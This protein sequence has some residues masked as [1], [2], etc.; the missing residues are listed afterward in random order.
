MYNL[1]THGNPE[2]LRIVGLVIYRFIVFF[3]IAMAALSAGQYLFDIAAVARCLSMW[4][5]AGMTVAMLGV[6]REKKMVASLKICS[7]DSEQRIND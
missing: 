6:L 5:M 7:Y 2:D 1:R 4:S 3:P